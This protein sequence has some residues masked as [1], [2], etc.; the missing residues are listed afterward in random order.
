MNLNSIYIK[1]DS[2]FSKFLNEWALNN[3][4]EILNYD[5]KSSDFPEGLLLINANQDIDRDHLDIHTLFD[6]KHIPTQ[7]IDVNGT[8]QV[9]VSNMEIWLNNFK[10]KNILILGSDTLL[11]M[12]ISIGSFL[13]YPNNFLPRNCCIEVRSYLS[14]V[15]GSILFFFRFDQSLYRAI[16][17][18]N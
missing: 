6:K 9:A 15:V 11:K 1:A 16:F 17:S 10:C 5:Q 18:I 12:R 7:K 3:D 13:E 4:V 2:D 14:H 8:L